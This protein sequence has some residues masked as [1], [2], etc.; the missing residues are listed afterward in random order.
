MTV[1]ELMAA[2]AASRTLSQLGIASYAKQLSTMCKI[3]C[4]APFLAAGYKANDLKKAV[5]GSAHTFRFGRTDHEKEDF[6]AF[7]K[8]L[9]QLGVDALET[10]ASKPGLRS[11]AVFLVPLIEVAQPAQ[12]IQDMVRSVVME[13]VVWLQPD[14]NP[15]PAPPPALLVPPQEADIV[16]V[17][18]HITG[19][20]F[21][22]R[23]S[24]EGTQ[25]DPRFN[26]AVLSI[27]PQSLDGKQQPEFRLYQKDDNDP[28]SWLNS[29]GD[30]APQ[31]KRILLLGQMEK[32]QLPVVS[33]WR[34]NYSPDEGV[35]FWR[36]SG[37]ILAVNSDK[38]QFA[39]HCESF[40]VTA[41]KD[42]DGQEFGNRL[43]KARAELGRK[44]R[45]EV[46]EILNRHGLVED[47]ISVVLD[48][49]ATRLGPSPVMTL[50][51]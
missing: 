17:T 37:L 41:S 33:V 36:T 46:V 15:A 35:P 43:E 45:D 1:S 8:A 23:P 28:I 26:V 13:D 48:N 50:P 6:V 27:R 20:W 30:V 47:S 42:V 25:S 39:A 38:R 10:D 18:P 22:V 49:L 12:A 14:V 2:R 51:N 4:S 16:S 3:G 21:V 24:A 19:L 11:V 5:T 44:T 40:R 34:Y 31:R 9:L 32:E 29:K 7:S